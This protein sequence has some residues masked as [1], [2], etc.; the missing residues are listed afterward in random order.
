[1][2]PMIEDLVLYIPS[3]EGLES[4]N[5]INSIGTVGEHFLLFEE[6]PWDVRFGRALLPCFYS[7]KR[8]SVTKIGTAK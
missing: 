3:D 8:S 4:W 7:L 5:V 6:T 2:Y 1:M